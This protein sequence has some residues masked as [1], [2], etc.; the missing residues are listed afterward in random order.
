MILNIF[1]KNFALIESRTVQCEAVPR[2]GEFVDLPADAMA[3]ADGLHQA[4]VHEVTWQLL[5]N[6]L[7]PEVNCHATGND[8]SN[9]LLRLEEQGWLQSRD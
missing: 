1:N 5:G 3:S 6:K 7:T 8:P 2:V 9:R 4:L